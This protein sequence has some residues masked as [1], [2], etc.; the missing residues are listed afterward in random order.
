MFYNGNKY[1]DNIIIA[2]TSYKYN[3]IFFIIS[4]PVIFIGIFNFE[5]LELSTGLNR[6][7]N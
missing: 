5:L 4:W 7:Y 3:E 6:I 1:K 2:G